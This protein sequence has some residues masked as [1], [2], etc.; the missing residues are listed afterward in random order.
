VAAVV[1]APPGALTP[2]Q[3]AARKAI[4]RQNTEILV[5]TLVLIVFAFFIGYAFRGTALAAKEGYPVTAEFGQVDGLAVGS[6]VTIAGLPVGQVTKLDLDLN[7]MRPIVTMII[8]RS[9][10]L[11]TDSS[12]RVATDGLLGPKFIKI[13]PGGDDETIPPG[14]HI[15]YVQD[16]VIVERLLKK[17]VNDAEARR[18]ERAHGTATCPCPKDGAGGKKSGD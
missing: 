4:A 16:A 17:I 14:G 2:E 9:I 5:G 12:A 18:E 3:A 1:N 15:E 11:P 8:D 7:G 6:Q 13:D 10:K